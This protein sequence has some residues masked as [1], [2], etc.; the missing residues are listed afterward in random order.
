M[1]DLYDEFR[2]TGNFEIVAFP[3]NQF[4]EQEPGTNREIKEFADDMGVQFLMM[5]KIDVNGAN[6]HRVYKHLKEK[7]GPE[8]IEWN[9]QT[10][11]IVDPDGR[12]IRAFSNTDP[13]NLRILFL[14]EFFPDLLEDMNGEEEGEDEDEDEDEEDSGDDGEEEED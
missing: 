14:E 13:Q 2:H 1:I 11:Y 10:Y 6:T 4:G 9:F 7:A 8:N 12:E 3:C 5:Q